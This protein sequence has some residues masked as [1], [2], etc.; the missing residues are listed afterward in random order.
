MLGERGDV[1]WPLAQGDGTLDTLQGYAR[2]M[3]QKFA[4]DAQ[5]GAAGE[6]ET[7]EETGESGTEKE[8]K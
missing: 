5:T 4:E 8:K 7:V 3:A 6:T 2:A 1:L